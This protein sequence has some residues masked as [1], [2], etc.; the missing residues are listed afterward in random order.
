MKNLLT[1]KNVILPGQLI[2]SLAIRLRVKVMA[3]QCVARFRPVPISGKKKVKMVIF[4]R[5]LTLR[6]PGILVEKRANKKGF[7]SGE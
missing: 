7:C 1:L 3:V 5:I 4:D 6:P 2:G